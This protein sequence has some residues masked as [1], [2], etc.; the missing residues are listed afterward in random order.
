MKFDVGPAGDLG[1]RLA[2]SQSPKP[3][4]TYSLLALQSAARRQF[5]DALIDSIVGYTTLTLFFH[6]LTLDRE[7]AQRWLEDQ[8]QAACDS[9][10]RA[11]TD[12]KTVTLPVLY[13]PSVAQD[14]EWLAEKQNMGID[15]II[16][17]HSGRDYFAYATG[18]APGFC[19]LGTVDERLATPRL[20][21]PRANVPPGS[22]AIAD[23]QT[24]VY[25][26][27]SPGGWRVIGTCPTR[28]FDLN[29]D[30]AALLCVGDTVK[31]EPISMADFRAVQDTQAKQ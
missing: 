13:H 3:S 16:E 8:A 17:L 10:G 15:D 19:Y 27:S 1:L 9:P 14:L 6:P 7:R 28:L 2:F 22:V 29:S 5:S 24:A 30:P 26:C 20:V 21:T 25:P 18:F 11:D 12:R 4:L 31:F 23:Q